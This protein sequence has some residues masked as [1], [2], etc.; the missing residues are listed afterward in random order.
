MATLDI[1]SY[2]LVGIALLLLVPVALLLVEVVAALLPG[3]ATAPTTAAVPHLAVLVPAHDEA[4]VIGEMLLNIAAEL[5]PGDRLIVVADNCTDVTAEIARSHGAEVVNR[6]DLSQRGKSFALDF[7]IRH[8]SSAPPEV[9]VIVDADCRLDQGSLR[10]IAARACQSGRPVQAHY[11]LLLPAGQDSAGR[12]IAVFASKVK[13]YLRPLGLNRLGLPCQLAG[14]GMALPWK[15]LMAVDLKSGE[16]AEDLVLGLDLARC[17]F[18]AEFCAAARVTSYFPPSAEGTRT[19]R[20][21][22]ETGHVTTILRRVPGLV[23]EAILTRNGPLLA[24]ALDAA[25]PPLA[26]QTVALLAVFFISLVAAAW[27]SYGALAVSAT[28]LGLFAISVL[29][30]WHRAGRDNITFLQL[31]AV[32]P[33]VLSKVPLYAQIFSGKRIPWIR[34]KRD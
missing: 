25:V 26:L 1:F 3:K 33:Y 10:T 13:N 30:A 15:A 27:G 32:P 8:L 18:A 2:A 28:A 12:G 17:G 31:A 6:N 4:T 34:S 14:T 5:A 7:G 24:L 9:V 11:E 20:A 23:V 22:W 21:R 29:L 16:L 19:Q